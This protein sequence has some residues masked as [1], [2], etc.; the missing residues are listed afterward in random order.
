MIFLTFRYGLIIALGLNQ[1]RYVLI[2]LVLEWLSWVFSI[3]LTVFSIKY[4]LVQRYFSLIFLVILLRMPGLIIIRLIL[5][6]GLPP[7]YKW[8]ITLFKFF[9][10]KRLLFA[11]T[12]HKILPTVFSRKCFSVLL[13]LLS[14]TILCI[15]FLRAIDLFLVLMFSSFLHGW[16]VIFAGYF[17]QKLFWQYWVVYRGILFLFLI[18]IIFSKSRLLSGGQTAF[19]GISFLILSGFPPF[20]LFWVKVSV[21]IVLVVSRIY[22][23]LILIFSSVIRLFV[24][25]RILCL[26][27][28]LRHKNNARLIPVLAVSLLVGFF[29]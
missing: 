21:F 13:R 11:I 27:L 18:S 4:L 8:V 16:W 14:I 3:T 19:R 1:T 6:M 7:F 20:L 24:Y 5:K 2:F 23:A 28:G 22:L 25:F 9:R 26:R 10:K 29:C 12:L 15:L 17:Y